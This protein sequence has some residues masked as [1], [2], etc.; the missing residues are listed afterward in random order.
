MSEATHDNKKALRNELR[1]RL[2]R[3][4]EDELAERSHAAA[5]RLFDEPVFDR[6]RVVMIF[7]SMPN[8]IDTR[9]IA[10]RCWQRQKTVTAPLVHF[11]QRHMI[12]VVIRSLNDPM[13]TDE[14]GLSNPVEGG[15]MPIEDIDLLIVPGLG[16]DPQGHR[17]GRGAG[18]YDRF[19]SQPGFRATTFGLSFDEQVVDTVP[20]QAHD[21]PLDGLI[22]DRRT[23]R[24]SA[25]HKGS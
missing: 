8:E 25:I 20:T 3:I 23:L 14:R 17:I 2:R 16:F 9:P 1:Q 15:P 13:D 12:P 11:E 10:L 7:L 4:G 5:Q 24:F 18:F 19:L 21:V 6:A 22:T